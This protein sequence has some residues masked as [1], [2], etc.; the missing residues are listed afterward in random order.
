MMEYEA[1]FFFFFLK[2][3]NRGG[4]LFEKHSAFALKSMNDGYSC[5][6]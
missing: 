2:K 4:V 3:N 5:S 6:K 1:V